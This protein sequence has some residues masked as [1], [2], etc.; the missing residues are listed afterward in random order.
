MGGFQIKSVNYVIN[1]ETTVV[2]HLYMVIN[3]E[4]ATIGKNTHVLSKLTFSL[5]FI[6]PQLE[7]ELNMSL[8]PGL[9]NS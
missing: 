2:D 4:D 5:L 1:Q 7:F 8:D 3:K 6:F 9:I